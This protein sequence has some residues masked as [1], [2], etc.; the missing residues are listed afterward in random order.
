MSDLQE[1]DG[2]GPAREEALKENGFE[3]YADLSDADPEVL[4]EEVDTGLPEDSALEI[5]VQA[6]N[7][8]DLQEAEVEENPSSEENESDT[9]TETEVKVENTYETGT[10][11]STETDESL[12]EED[13]EEVVDEVFD[14]EDEEEVHDIELTLET[15]YQYDALYD[16]LLQ[17]RKTLIGTNRSGVEETTERLA[18]VR[19]T[20]VGETVTFTLTDNEINDLH[21]VISR[22]R[23]DYQSKNLKDQLAGARD[24]ETEFNNQR[25]EILF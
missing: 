25:R 19:E 7:L 18:A 13:V 24:I 12:T 1:I 14:K 5:V 2:V 16:S 4:S 17:H 9:E 23:L 3:T 10:V 15:G 20:V 6:Q 22:Q 21:S 11:E 8:A